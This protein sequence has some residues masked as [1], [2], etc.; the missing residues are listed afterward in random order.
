[1]ESIELSWGSHD[2][3]RHDH[4]AP[5]LTPA[6]KPC[7]P[8]G[9]PALS[10]GAP[11]TAASSPARHCCRS[12]T[13]RRP[14]ARPALHHRSRR[15]GAPGIAGRHPRP[16][17][18]RR[19]SR[20]GRPGRRPARD[21]VLIAA[22]APWAGALAVVGGQFATCPAR[23]A[24]GR[25][26]AATGAPRSTARRMTARKAGADMPQAIG[27]FVADAFAFGVAGATVGTAALIETAVTFA[28][29]GC[30]TSPPKAAGAPGSQGGAAAP[31]C[32][33]PRCARVPP[34]ALDLRHRQDRRGAGLRRAKHRRRRRLAGHRAGRGRNRRTGVHMVG[35]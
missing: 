17:R 35:G 24:C 20:A 29:S 2:A 25:C 18:P 31:W 16:D 1:M 14:P 12:T 33:T 7:S 9:A 26:R 11:R 10:A 5:D 23:W 6:C 27:A 21:L 4:P 19:P 28:A 8:P 15:A 30:S 13:F 34:R 3:R 22:P 32:S